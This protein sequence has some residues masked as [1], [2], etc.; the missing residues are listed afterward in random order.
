VINQ[1]D[2]GIAR[3]GPRLQVRKDEN[4]W[5]EGTPA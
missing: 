4:G 2:I 1:F 3:L 5:Q